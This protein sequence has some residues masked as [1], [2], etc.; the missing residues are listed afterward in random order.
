MA[1][2]ARIA[3]AAAA[4]T[5]VGR[6]TPRDDSLPAGLEHD[7]LADVTARALAEAGIGPADVGS[8]IFTQP[9]PTTRQLGFATFMCAQLGFTCSGLVTEV[10]QLGLTGG[11]AFD[12]AAAE[13]QLGRA[14]YA[15]ALGVVMQSQ[16]DTATA[17]EFGIRAVGDVDYQAPFGIPPIGWYALDAERYMHETGASRADLAQ[18]AV[19]SRANAIH[20]PL[21]QF[22]KPLT[23]EEV[24]EQRPIV[25]PLGLLEVPARTDG[26]ICLVLCSEETARRSQQP[27]ALLSGRGFHHE[28][29]HQISDHPHDMTA[30]PVARKASEDALAGA[31]LTLSDIDLSELYAPCT[32]TEILVSEA[33]GLFPRGGGV[34]G[35]LEGKTTPA[36]E[37]P[38]NTSGG[39]L[40]RGHPTQVTPLYGLMELREQLLGQ[41]G[42]RQVASAKRALHICELGNYNA[43]LAHVLELCE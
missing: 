14:E 35:L 3:I 1:G 24:L 10:N 19:K 18:V 25:E 26:A 17:M 34:R 23:P 27:F 11:V 5:P 20:N 21:A 6:L 41:A 7:I 15:L 32:I 9:P 2:P 42:E 31:G 33:I 4:A 43:A 28:G 8:A 36:G 30:F 40:S 29:F 22:R 12:L 16:G 13:I 38:I 39:C 37:H